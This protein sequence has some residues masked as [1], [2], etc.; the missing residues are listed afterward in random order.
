MG[1]FKDKMIEEGH[2]ASIIEEAAEELFTTGYYPWKGLSKKQ[3]EEIEE[4]ASIMSDDFDAG[5]LPGWRG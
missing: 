5:D 3:R 2:E 1:V 4:R